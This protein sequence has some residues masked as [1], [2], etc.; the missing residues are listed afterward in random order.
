[1]MGISILMPALIM[2]NLD[3]KHPNKLIGYGPP[4]SM[5][6][7]DTWRYANKKSA[8]YLLWTAIVVITVQFVSYFLL[9]PKQSILL[10]AGVLVLGV[11]I[12][13]VLTEVGL[14]QHFDKS[15][16]PK[17]DADRY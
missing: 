4:R 12:T 17:L 16:Q 7:D 11:I 10:G 9:D 2:K 13:M 15:G 5:K 1:M 6:S 8:N 14:R 3:L